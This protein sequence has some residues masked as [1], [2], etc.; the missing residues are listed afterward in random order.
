[1]AIKTREVR[2]KLFYNLIWE[3]N[4]INFNLMLKEWHFKL[5]VVSSLILIFFTHLSM[6]KKDC[7]VYDKIYK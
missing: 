5:E 6:N 7:L 1:M 2:K 3:R 4:K